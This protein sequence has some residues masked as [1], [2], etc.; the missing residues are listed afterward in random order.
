MARRMTPLKR[1]SLW[2]TVSFCPGPRSLSRLCYFGGVLT[3]AGLIAAVQFGWSHGFL[4]V[5]E[6]PSGEKWSSCRC[7]LANRTESYYEKCSRITTLK[8]FIARI[9]SDP[10]DLRNYTSPGIKELKAGLADLQIQQ[11]KLQGDSIQR[12]LPGLLVL[13]ALTIAFSLLTARLAVR[14]ASHVGL[15]SPSAEELAGWKWPFWI[16]VVAL[17]SLQE[18]REL[19]TSV[20][21][22]HKTW[23]GWQSFCLCTPAWIASQ[24]M[25]LG[26]YIVISCPACILWCLS[27]RAYRPNKL[28]RDDKDGA[29]GVGGYVLFAQTWSL[30][31]FIVLLVPTLLW[32]RSNSQYVT[33]IYL[34]PT[35][36]LLTGAGMVAARLLRNVIQLRLLYQDELQSLGT[37]T[38][39]QA[40]NPPPDPTSSFLG[41]RWWNLPAVILATMASFWAVIEWSGV[42][43]LLEDLL[44]GGH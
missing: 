39:I 20:L 6:L 2:K 30:L 33:F 31:M 37:W 18:F 24:I 23:F 38:K 25:A 10:E 8:A 22:Q 44:F 14:H 11:A 41:D 35:L 26:A 3:I 42:G 43:K 12:S 17:F 7:Q 15:I 27:R 28:E 29:W 21:A 40:S 5:T 32:I 9:Q 36:G 19:I 16:F 1:T 34:L 13:L 4:H